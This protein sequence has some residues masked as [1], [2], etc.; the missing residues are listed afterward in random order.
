M[1]ASAQLA[2]SFSPESVLSFGWTGVLANTLPSGCGTCHSHSVIP[3]ACTMDAKCHRFHLRNFFFFVHQGG[4]PPS[5]VWV[6]SKK[7]SP[8]SHGHDPYF[9]F[10][11]CF[12]HSLGDTK[13]IHGD[14]CCHFGLFSGSVCL[15]APPFVDM[16]ATLS[17]TDFF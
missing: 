2:Y 1:Q 16:A 10:L 5:L 4:G 3:I 9:L 7:K 17:L 6:S 11:P 15:F 14:T 8:L 13:V 12:P